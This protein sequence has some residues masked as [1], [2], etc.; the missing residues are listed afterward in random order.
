MPAH[1]ASAQGIYLAHKLTGTA[2]GVNLDTVPSCIYTDPEIAGVGLTEQQA[3]EANIDYKVGRFVFRA[4]G[5][6]LVLGKTKGF[7]KI[8][9]GAKYGEVLGVHIIGPYATE[10]IAGCA[11]AM[12]LEACVED[13]ANTIH[14]HPTVSESIME[15][16][17]GF[18]GGAIHLV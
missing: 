14:A 15:A 2:S 3:K 10:L 18:L 6:S 11:V 17:E 4:N 13:I 12:K 1:A 5:R 9:G 16:A 7:V 8:I